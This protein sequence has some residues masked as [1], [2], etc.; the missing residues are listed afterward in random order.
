MSSEVSAATSSGFGHSGQPSR[1]NTS[2]QRQ[3]KTLTRAKRGIEDRLCMEVF[4][5]SSPSYGDA[6]DS[7]I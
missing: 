3:R 7:V 5:S 1:A 6:T 4:P 2:A